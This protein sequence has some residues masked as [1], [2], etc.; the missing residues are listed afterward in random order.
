MSRRAT[1]RAAPW[2]ASTRTAI[3]ASPRGSIDAQIGGL[4]GAA[5]R[6]RRFCRETG[7]HPAVAAAR[8][9]PHA[10]RILLVGLG[11]RAGFGRKQY[12]KAL[13]SSAQALTKTGASDAIVYLALEEVAELET[14]VPRPHGGRGVLWAGLQDSRSEDRR[15]AETAQTHRASAWRRKTRG[16]PKRWRTASRSA[17]QSAAGLPCRA[18]WRTCRPISVRPPTSVSAPRLGQ[19]VAAH[20][21]QGAG[22]ERHQGLEDGCI[23]RGDPRVRAAAAVDRVRVSRSQERTARRF[24][25]SAR[26]SPSIRAEY[27]SRIRRPWTR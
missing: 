3:S 12:R 16:R 15:E 22:R 6:A 1:L 2:S 17:P 18:I 25:W 21:D 5:A 8:R 7:R 9:A 14:A 10:A 26:G 11:S 13:Q 23:P 20:Q 24:A 19:G 4:I 27:P